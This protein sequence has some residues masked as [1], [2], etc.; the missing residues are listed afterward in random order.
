MA[1][2]TAA[3]SKL[4]LSDGAATAATSVEFAALT[5]LEVGEITNIGEFGKAFQDIAT[6]TINQRQ[7]KHAKGAF[8]EGTL[9]LTVYADPDD[10]GQ[11]EALLALE[12]DSEWGIKITL[13]DGAA[14]PTTIYY[15]GLVSSFRRTISDVNSMVT[16]TIAIMLNTEAVEVPAT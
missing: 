16:A 12:S 4:Y 13:N 14:T 2:I 15:R 5:W 11:A 1:Q 9:N 7:T 10:P 3:G 8:D 6:N